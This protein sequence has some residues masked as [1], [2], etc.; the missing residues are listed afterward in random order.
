MRINDVSSN[1][2]AQFTEGG[3][4]STTTQ[5]T[6]ITPHLV[7]EVVTRLKVFER[8]L[9]VYLTQRDLPEVDLSR[10]AGSATYYK[11][12]LAHRPD[13]EYGDVDVQFHV[14]KLPNMSAN[15]A[16]AV[17]KDAIKDFLRNNT[18]FST[19]NGVNIIV[20]VRAGYVQ[21][22][23]IYSFME[24]RAWTLALAPEYKVKGVLCNSLYS[25]LGLA[26]NISFGG[27]HGVQAKTRG[28]ELVPFSVQKDVELTTISLDPHN[29]ALDIARY[30]GATKLSPRLKK[31]PGLLDE[32]RVT[33]IVSS[34]RGIAETLEASGVLPKPY[35]T[36]ED[37]IHKVKEIYL[38]K[39]NKATQSTKFHKATTP[40]AQAKAQKT[41][42]SL[43]DQSAKI[44]SLF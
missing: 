31:Y 3:W 26:L 19:D 30:F 32:V 42:Q 40:D 14:H 39:I 21:V 25:S 17:Y 44:A 27:G 10:P 37:L 20:K 23:L 36:A 34:I 33:D 6:K 12:D 35:Q 8:E 15:A 22:D 5:D 18:E 29:W 38:D 7:A 4:A 41:K 2:Q 13:A 28:G 16:L 24:A 9:N 11:R 1:K 43:A